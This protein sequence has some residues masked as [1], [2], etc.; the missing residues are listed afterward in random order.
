[1][2]VGEKYQKNNGDVYFYGQDCVEPGTKLTR[3]MNERPTTT[4]RERGLAYI[5]SLRVSCTPF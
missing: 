4:R 5:P 3:A 2:D 1:M